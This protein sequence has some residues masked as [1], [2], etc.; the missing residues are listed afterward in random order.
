VELDKLSAPGEVLA[1]LVP[2]RETVWTPLD[3]LMVSVPVRVPKTVGENI[4][5]TVQL[6]PAAIN[7]VHVVVS[8]KSP[9]IDTPLLVTDVVPVFLTVTAIPPLVVPVACCENVRLVGE[10]VT[11]PPATVPVSVSVTTCGLF[12][13]ES[14]NVNVPLANPDAV[15]VNVTPTVQVPLAAML[16]PH[17]LFVIAKGAVAAM[18]LNGIA[19]AV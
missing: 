12:K 11:V 2:L 10:T 15:G 4:T 1:E 8:A 5:V 19:E 13:A 6:F 14:A 9:E 3:R 17:V 7:D 18:L 16:A